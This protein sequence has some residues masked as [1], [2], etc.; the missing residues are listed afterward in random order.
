M[1]DWVVW[2]EG[3]VMLELFGFMKIYGNKVCVF[4]G[5]LLFIFKGMFGFFGLNGVGKLMLMC[6]IV[7]L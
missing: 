7:M 5:V 4:D 1:R 6:M 2:F 3:V